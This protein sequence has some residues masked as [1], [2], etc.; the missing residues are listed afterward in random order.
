MLDENTGEKGYITVFDYATIDFNKTNRTRPP[1][2]N[3]E[4]EERVGNVIILVVKA[5]VLGR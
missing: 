4:K 2:D 1:F 5:K 3:G